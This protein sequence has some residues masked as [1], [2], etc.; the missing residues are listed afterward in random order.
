M[1]QI[2]RYPEA[3]NVARRPGRQ[4]AMHGGNT[5]LLLWRLFDSGSSNLVMFVVDAAVPPDGR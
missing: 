4:P 2:R 5:Q 3:R 1:S